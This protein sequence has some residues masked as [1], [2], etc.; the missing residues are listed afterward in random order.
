MNPKTVFVRDATGLVRSLTYIDVLFLS[1]AVTGPNYLSYVLQMNFV[2]GVDPGAD[3]VLS[4]IYG[5]LF[6]IPLCIMYYFFVIVMPR[7]GGDYVWLS[8]V[9]N[10]VVGFVGG[11]AMWVSWIVLAAGTSVIFASVVVPVWFASLGYSWNI[12]SWVSFASNFSNSYVIFLV[13]LLFL[14]AGILINSRGPTLYRRSMIILA[15]VQWIG[16]FI[17][18]YVLATTSNQTFV[19]AFNHYGGVNATYTGII[20]QAKSSGWTF[21]PIFTGATL[22]AIPFGVLWFNGF[23]WSAS[24]SGEV[25]HVKTGMLWGIVGALI[26]DAIIN[27]LGVYWGVNMV[28]YQFNQAALYLASN[29]P[30]QWP[31]AVG[32]WLSLFTPMVVQNPVILF[33]IQL[34]WLTSWLWWVGAL[35]FGVSRYVF[36]FSFDRMLPVRFADVNERYRFPFNATALCVVVGVIFIYLTDFTTYIGTYLNST[37]IFAIVWVLVSIAA[38]IFP[39]NKRTKELASTLPGGKWRVPLMSILGVVCFFAFCM[40]I[41]YAFTTPAVGP[42]TPFSDVILG[43][44]FA[45]GALIFVVRYFYLKRQGI[46]LLLATREI[47]PE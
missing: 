9:L 21:T 13:A 24:A 40:T 29:N 8:R 15:V 47:P 1:L 16:T 35:V 3:I 4:G 44:I 42:S 28:G 2:G 27:L 45:L 12:P 43:V 17:C 38:I 6:M 46:D 34:S 31:F 10:P 18:L 30:S 7:S 39:Y 25:R 5:L 33:L 32:P 11:W 22:L 41:Y 36:A 14:G 26:I 23:N 19:T 37:A 20:Q